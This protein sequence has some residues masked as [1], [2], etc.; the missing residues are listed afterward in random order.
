MSELISKQ[1]D[2]LDEIAK[3]DKKKKKKVKDGG[4]VKKFKLGKM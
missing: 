3:K 1:A 4:K 2:L